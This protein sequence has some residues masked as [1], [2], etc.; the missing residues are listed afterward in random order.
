MPISVYDLLALEAQ[1][2]PPPTATFYVVRVDGDPLD[3]HAAETFEGAL[4][5]ATPDDGATVHYG[6]VKA[7]D[8]GAARL[9]KPSTWTLY[10]SGAFGAT[11]RKLRTGACFL[12]AAILSLPAFAAE[13]CRINV[14][15]ATPA[16]LQLFA[17]TGPVLASKLASGRPYKALPDVDAVKGIGPS[18]LAINGPHVAFSGPTTCTAKIAAPKVPKVPAPSPLL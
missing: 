6:T 8:A 12:L 13:P 1:S 17:R 14:N 11:S 5:L 2:T 7:R 9:M 16:Q 18:W 10:T 3:T 15:A 4:A